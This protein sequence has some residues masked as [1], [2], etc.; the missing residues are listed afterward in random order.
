MASAVWKAGVGLKRTR[1]IRPFVSFSTISLSTVFH[2]PTPEAFEVL[3]TLRCEQPLP[4]GHL[5]E[6]ANGGK[7]V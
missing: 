2:H 4:S 3:R 7:I 6:A 1:T 5:A